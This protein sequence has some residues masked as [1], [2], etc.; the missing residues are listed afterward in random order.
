M[1]AIQLVGCREDSRVFIAKLQV[2]LHPSRG[3]L[4]TLAIVAVRQRHDEAGT[5][6]PFDFSRCD[7]LIDDAL[8]IVGKVA[9]LGFPYD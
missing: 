9:K 1:L 7:E 8:A 5:L 6:Q 3:V 4:W 2:S